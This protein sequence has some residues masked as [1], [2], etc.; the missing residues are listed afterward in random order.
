MLTQRL[1]NALAGCVQL[2]RRPPAYNVLVLFVL[3]VV[4][5]SAIAIEASYSFTFATDP[6]PLSS[7]SECSASYPVLARTLLGYMDAAKTAGEAFAAL[8]ARSANGAHAG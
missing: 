5:S 1:E 4:S 7:E 6:R 8:A 3:V 2:C